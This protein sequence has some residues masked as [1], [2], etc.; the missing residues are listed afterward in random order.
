MRTS[1]PSTTIRSFDWARDV[2]CV[3]LSVSLVALFL[4]ARPTVDNVCAG[5]GR[6]LAQQP[7]WVRVRRRTA[8]LEVRGTAGRK[9]HKNPTA[10]TARC[11]L[12]PST[13][14]HHPRDANSRSLQR[15]GLVGQTKGITRGGRRHARTSRRTWAVAGTC[16][17]E[18]IRTRGPWQ[19]PPMPPRGTPAVTHLREVA[20]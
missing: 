9:P 3:I 15:W 16:C 19:H 7:H 11:W 8:C 6:Q 4:R 10:T 12:W 13:H 5:P 1:W 20:Q 2:P 14:T 18:Q 17:V